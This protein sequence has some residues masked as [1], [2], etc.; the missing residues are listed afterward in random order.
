MATGAF[1]SC[2]AGTPVHNK[3]RRREQPVNTLRKGVATLAISA[4]AIGTPAAVA[5]AATA[6]P[7][8]HQHGL[9]NVVVKHVLNHNRVVILKNIPVS[10]AAAV[11]DVHVNVLSR[12]LQRDNH[13]PCGA[14]SSSINKAFVEYA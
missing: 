2:L 4:A 10:T 5:G 8:V 12:E 11:C 1:T 6:S 7:A 14:L 9:V 13:A 3:L